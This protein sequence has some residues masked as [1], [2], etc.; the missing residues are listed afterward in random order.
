MLTLRSLRPGDEFRVREIHDQMADE[1][2]DFVFH[3]ELPWP[4]LL[5]QLAKEATGVDL[6]P[7]RVP[8]D[9]L[10][11]E[12][13]GEIVGRTSIRHELNDFLLAYGGHIGYGVAPEHRRRGHATE[14]L[15]QSIARLGELGVTQVLVTCD[16]DNTGSAKVIEACGGVL[17]DVRPMPGEVP[18]RRYWIGSQTSPSGRGQP[19][20]S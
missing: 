18:K 4:E 11:A 7:D 6:P 1:D 20:L 13:D 14:I 3:A 10:V 16:D 8:C 17:A 9:F 5:A 19:P 2:F 15:R 12:V